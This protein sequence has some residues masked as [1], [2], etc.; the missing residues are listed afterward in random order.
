MLR[1]GTASRCRHG[2]RRQRS[3]LLQRCCR[4]LYIA[5]F[6]GHLQLISQTVLGICKHRAWVWSATPGIFPF[7]AGSS[8]GLLGTGGGWWQGRRSGSEAGG[9]A[10]QKAEAAL[11]LPYAHPPP[12]RGSDN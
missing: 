4:G 8:T 10:V 2:S 11:S 1:R 5:F 12:L 7:G 9:C 3:S 6:F